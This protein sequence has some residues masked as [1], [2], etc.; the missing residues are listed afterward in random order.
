MVMSDRKTQRTI[1]VL[2][3]LYGLDM[4]VAQYGSG[5]RVLGSLLT[6]SLLALLRPASV[7]VVVR[8]QVVILFVSVMGPAE[9]T[10]TVALFWASLASV[11]LS[12]VER[13]Y[14]FRLLASSIYG[15]A[16]LQKLLSAAWMRGDVFDVFFPAFA[17]PPI[18][19]IVA[20]AEVVLGTLVYVAPRRAIFAVILLHVGI[21]IF[22]STDVRHGMSLAVYGILMVVLVAAGK[23]VAKTWST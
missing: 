15:F 7:D 20:I 3:G 1:A 17:V 2:S 12:D 14:A 10:M 6:V 11:A 19:G 5:S 16:G 4:I 21:V 13:A 22:I 8:F 23:D 18:P 9:S